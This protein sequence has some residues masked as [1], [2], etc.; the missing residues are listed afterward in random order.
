MRKERNGGSNFHRQDPVHLKHALHVTIIN[1]LLAIMGR[2]K[3]KATLHKRRDT[4][5]TFS[6]QQFTSLLSHDFHIPL[7]FCPSFCTTPSRKPSKNSLVLSL[8][9]SFGVE[10]CGP[11]LSLATPVSLRGD[12]IFVKLAE[13]P[14]VAEGGEVSASAACWLYSCRVN[15][16]CFVT[17]VPRV[18]GEMGV[19]GLVSEPWPPGAGACDLLKRSRRRFWFEDGR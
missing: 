15:A 19:L 13:A 14:P 8:S 9:G 10:T 1:A 5:L 12:G 4:F 2:F 18:K 17:G 3:D 7:P 6:P 11:A 16:H